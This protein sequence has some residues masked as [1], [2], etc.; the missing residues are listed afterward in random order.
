MLSLRF[1][2]GSLSH[3]GKENPPGA[4]KVNQRGGGTT[5][6]HL[7]FVLDCYIFFRSYLNR[8]LFCVIGIFFRYTL[9]TYPAPSVSHLQSMIWPSL[10]LSSTE[11]AGVWFNSTWLNVADFFY[12]AGYKLYKCMYVILGFCLHLMQ[13]Q[14]EDKEGKMARS[15]VLTDRLCSQ[16]AHNSV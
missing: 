3:S 1:K 11:T 16:S 8:L 13:E 4:L 12:S 10:T 14:H 9:I 15:M 7:T 5:H 2:E 6:A